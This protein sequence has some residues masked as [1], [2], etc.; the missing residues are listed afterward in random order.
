MVELPQ[1]T[2][3]AT[4]G[5]RPVPADGEAPIFQQGAVLEALVQRPW[6]ESGSPN[7]ITPSPEEECDVVLGNSREEDEFRARRRATASPGDGGDGIQDACLSG[8]NFK[9][10]M[11]TDDGM[12]DKEL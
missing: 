12:T 6:A 8:G 2:V 7:G 9:G 11:F 3:D 10:F 1:V 4:R 5:Y